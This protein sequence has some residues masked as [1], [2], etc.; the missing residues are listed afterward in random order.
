[1]S[2]KITFDIKDADLKNVINDKVNPFMVF[3][4]ILRH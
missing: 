3:Q 4:R 2:N 1:M